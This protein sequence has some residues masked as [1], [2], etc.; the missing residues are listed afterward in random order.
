MHQPGLYFPFPP[1]YRKRDSSTAR[2]LS[3]AR[4]LLDAEP[5][6]GPDWELMRTLRTN[7]DHLVQR[8]SIEHARRDWNG[9]EWS[10]G[11]PAGGTRPDLGW[12]LSLHKLEPTRSLLLAGSLAPPAAAAA[13]LDLVGAAKVSVGVGALAAVGGA[14]W[15]VQ[16]ACANARA[17][18][19]VGYLLDAHDHLT[20]RTLAGRVRKVFRGTYS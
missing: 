19:P 8:Y 15:Q 12:I 13:A 7:A 17:N 20:P 5:G 18:S 16:S 9:R 6:F 4:V 14:W 3:D 11:S 10:E 2:A 1:G